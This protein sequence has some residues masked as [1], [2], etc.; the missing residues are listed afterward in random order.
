VFVIH[1]FVS[2]F[3]PALLSGTLL[4][5]Q[6]GSVD[7]SFNASDL[8]YGAGDGPVTNAL[9]AL[10][11]QADGGVLIGGSL[12]RFNNVQRNNLVRLAPDGSVDLS[13]AP[14]SLGD[15]YDLVVQPDGKILVADG[16]VRRLL[17]NGTEDPTFQGMACCAVRRLQRGTRS[18]VH[19]RT[20]RLCQQ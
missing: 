11:I 17:P 13:F 8:G 14:S 1:R 5:Q 10:A 9:N 4:A 2:V 12:Q 7:L 18:F 3:L 16:L 20:P 19:I 15:V 6:P